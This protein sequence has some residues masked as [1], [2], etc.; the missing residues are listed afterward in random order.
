MEVGLDGFSDENIGSGR[1]EM[2]IRRPFYRARIEVWCHL[3]VVAFGEDRDFPGLP[4]AASA[5]QGGLQDGCGAGG[6]D[7]SK[8]GFRCKAFAGCDRDGGCAG[9]L[10]HGSGVVRWHGLFVPERV[11]GFDGFGHA[12]GAAGGELA[13]RSEE[14]V[15]AGA[16]SF[17]DGFAEGDGGVD[18]V[19]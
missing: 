18:V 13:M 19:E 10:G 16:D 4:D 3:G 2:D 6:E 8:F 1:G 5:S 7:R 14:E 15:G 9:N 11:I 12:D 17:T